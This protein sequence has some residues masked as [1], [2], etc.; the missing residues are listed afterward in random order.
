MGRAYKVIC[1]VNIIF[2][3]IVFWAIGGIPTDGEDII[4]IFS[5][6][7]FPFLFPILISI[8][9]ICNAETL[10][11]V[12]KIRGLLK[13]SLIYNLLIVPAVWWIVGYRNFYLVFSAFVTIVKVEFVSLII[14]IAFFVNINKQYKEL[15]DKS[16]DAVKQSTGKIYKYKEVEILLTLILSSLAIIFAYR[17]N[18]KLTLVKDIEK[19]PPIIFSVNLTGSDKGT[20]IYSLGNEDLIKVSD[21]IFKSLSY[22]EDRTKIVGVIEEEEGFNGIAELNLIDNSFKEVLSVEELNEFGKNN[23]LYIFDTS[24]GYWNTG[25]RIRTPKYYKDSYTFIYDSNICMLSDK[26]GVKNIEIIRKKDESKLYSYYIDENNENILYLE[27][28]E[29]EKNKPKIVIVKENTADKS[30]EVI[31]QRS[32]GTYEK[33]NIDGLMEIPDGIGELFY[34]KSPYISAYNL[35]SG[36]KNKLIRHNLFVKNMLDIKLS[37]DKQYLFYTIVEEDVFYLSDY[38]YTFCVVDLKNGLRA[39]LKRWYV[40]DIFYGFDW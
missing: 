10:N 23:E 15:I 38:R 2:L 6:I 34:Y 30:V 28:Y 16:D 37:K 24:D 40:K 21:H 13:R 4:L 25:D 31:T 36:L 19:E 17:Y 12:E 27:K 29:Y 3:C 14:H 1:T 7:Y 22:N 33:D 35:E 39:S 8:I 26:Q 11:N 5:C 9:A 20:F 18:V 32:K